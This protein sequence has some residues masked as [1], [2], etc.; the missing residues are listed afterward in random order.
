MMK[1]LD[2]L[3]EELV[4]YYT[5][6]Y[7]LPGVHVEIEI[8]KLQERGY[9][10]KEAII[11]LY[12][13]V[14]KVKDVKVIEEVESKS[15]EVRALVLKREEFI[16]AIVHMLAYTSV[17]FGSWVLYHLMYDLTTKPQHLALL[18]RDIF[19]VI[20]WIVWMFLFTLKVTKYFRR[21]AQ[22]SR[23]LLAKATNN[24]RN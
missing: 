20:V 21:K 16:D 7:T 14:F 12:K 19:L 9:S 13:E 10:R 4:E 11:K 6:F 3:Y 2:D 18:F 23:G 15:H 5:K 17:L 1:S 24:L 22:D 8:S